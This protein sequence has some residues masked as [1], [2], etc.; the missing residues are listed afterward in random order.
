MNYKSLVINS[1]ALLTFGIGYNIFFISS[2]KAQVLTFDTIDSSGGGN[3]NEILNVY[4]NDNRLLTQVGEDPIQSQVFSTHTNNIGDFTLIGEL[5]QNTGIGNILEVVIYQSGGNNGTETGSGTIRDFLDTL[6]QPGSNT[7]TR[8]TETTSLVFGLGI[9]ESGNSPLYQVDTLE[10]K[11]QIPGSGCVSDTINTVTAE[12]CTFTLGDSIEITNN[13]G[14]NDAEIKFQSDLDDYLTGGNDLFSTYGYS[15][16]PDNT[17]ASAGTSADY[18]YFVSSLV[19][20]NTAGNDRLFLSSGLTS[21]AEES[22]SFEFS[23][24]LGLI[25]CSGIFSSL[26]FIK[27]S[28]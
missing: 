7:Q 15:L 19:S 4:Y 8:V 18:N 2:I 21:V 13:G 11:L 17:L 25:L 20:N 6:A 28:V 26:R 23:P 10:I 27:K 9:N 3:N 5:N 16:N 12:T 24:G 22:I 14:N 1:L